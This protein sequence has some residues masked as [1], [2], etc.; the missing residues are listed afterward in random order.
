[1][2]T[3]MLSGGIAA[4]ALLL[5]VV[6]PAWPQEPRTDKWLSRPVDEKTLGAYAEFFEYDR[7]LPFDPQILNQKE[8]E[9]VQLEH[10]S[11][12]S[13]PGERVFG[14]LSAPSG[15]N[16]REFPAVVLLHGGAAPGKD[17]PRYVA[18]TELLTRGGFIVLAID[19]K[20]FGER[21][22]GV[23]TKFTEVEKHEQLYNQPSLY[24]SWVI[25]VVKDVGRSIDYLV[26][27]K[28]VN[29]KRIG[30]IGVS[31]GA[32]VGFIAVA[33][34]KRLSPAVF[35]YGGHFDGLE[36]EHLA[37]ACPANYIGR[38]APRPLLMVNGERDTDYDMETQVKP[39]FS[40][41]KSPKQIMWL[42]GGHSSYADKDLS[43]IM[44][45][46]HAHLK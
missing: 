20:Y 26:A 28:G 11:F 13:T 31:R 33:V 16:P 14:N 22:S 19:M 8:T 42:P 4:L 5:T 45:W 7:N 3:R 43:A 21:T 35:L 27:E 23:L 38:I 17:A 46:L 2:N 25:Q 12:Q 32:E 40:L 39:L 36:K 37:A 1:M 10:F 44:E 6:F 9:G 15:R 30:F 34:E 41:A 24:L 18:L 29:P